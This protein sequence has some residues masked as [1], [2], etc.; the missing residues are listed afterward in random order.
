M[1]TGGSVQF[2]RRLQGSYDEPEVQL[3]DAPAGRAPSIVLESRG[4]RPVW[5]ANGLHVMFDHVL[6]Q[7]I[8]PP[9]RPLITIDVPGRDWVPNIFDVAGWALDR[10]AVDA[11]GIDT[12]HLWAFPRDGSAPTFMGAAAVGVSRP[13]VAAAFGAQYAAAGFS[14]AVSLPAGRWTLTA[15]AHSAFTNTFVSAASATANVINT[16][17]RIIIDAPLAGSIRG[18]FV[19]SGWA[20]DLAAGSPGI[21]TGIDVVHVYAYR[22]DGRAVFLG[23]AAYAD[24]RPDVAARWG[25]RYVNSG[26]HLAV[27]TLPQ[28]HYR[29]AV[30]A[31]RTESFTFA[32]AQLREVTIKP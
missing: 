4:G 15:Y 31:R 20:L 32:P 19:I 28:G 16:S 22:D 14:R 6:L 11:S 7:V 10:S 8:Q 5:T 21:G 1:G 25:N 27:T 17:A 26:F 23:A 9:P 18:P 2:N 3:Y 29:L 30:F 24:A 12:V 13:D